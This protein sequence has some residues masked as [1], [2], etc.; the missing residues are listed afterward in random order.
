MCRENVL[1]KH[2]E[3]Y[4]REKRKRVRGKRR[5]QGEKSR[6]TQVRRVGEEELESGEAR[7]GEWICW[8]SCN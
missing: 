8:F 6:S 5:G 2:L 1:K 3:D 7:G 4:H